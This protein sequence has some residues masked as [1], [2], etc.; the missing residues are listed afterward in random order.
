MNYIGIDPGI[1]GGIAVIAATGALVDVFKMPATER[2]LLDALQPYGGKDVRSRAVLEAAQSSPQMGVA[3]AFSY[4]RGYGALLM[5]LTGARIPFR[6]VRAAAWQKTM[7]CRSGGDKNV[8]KRAAQHYFPTLTVT[9]AIADALLLAEYC[10]LLD[11]AN[12]LTRETVLQQ[13]KR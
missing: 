1:S 2:D 13:P 3:S 6:T 12:V 11:F 8:T 7:A 4:G 9:H 10:R 5:A